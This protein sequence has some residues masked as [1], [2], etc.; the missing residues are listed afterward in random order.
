MQI[1]KRLKNINFDKKRLAFGP[2]ITQQT[3]INIATVIIGSFIFA[4]GVNSFMIAGNLGEGG[5]TGLAIILYYAFDISPAVSNFV[6]NSILL[7][8][9]FKFLSRRA[10]YYTIVVVFLTSFFL[11]LTETWRIQTDE[12]LINTV[13]GGALVGLGIGLIIRIGATTA[14]TTILARLVNKYMDVN[15]SYALMFFDM[16][17]ITIG[18]TV[19]TLEQVLLTVI[20][21][22]IAMKVMDFII[23]GMNPKKAITIISDHPDRLGKMINS[24]IRRGVTIMNGRG[25]YTQEDKDILYVIINKSQLT[26]LKRLIRRYDEKAF[27]VV[28][29]VNSVLGNYFI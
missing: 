1:R 23:E 2:G 15:V 12:I 24:E 27:V 8:I 13:F 18:L 14:G 7:V 3:L 10:M 25:F 19:M 6:L 29:D 4:I 20:A 21:L 16:V 5:V 17:V 26:R 9:G 22:Y 28:H 11:W